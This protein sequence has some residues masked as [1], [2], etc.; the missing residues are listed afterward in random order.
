MPE[1]ILVLLAVPLE[2]IGY[3]ILASMARYPHCTSH[4][5]DSLNCTTSNFERAEINWVYKRK[6]RFFKKIHAINE[7]IRRLNRLCYLF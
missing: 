4:F 6:L 7:L 2:C 5:S 1:Q 3:G